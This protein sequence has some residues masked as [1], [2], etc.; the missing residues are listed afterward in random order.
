MVFN[1]FA[2]NFFNEIWGLISLGVAYMR[3]R[4]KKQTATQA[5][6]FKMFCGKIEP[7]YNRCF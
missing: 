3:L 2:K 7:V 1:G 5:I 4:G 6:I